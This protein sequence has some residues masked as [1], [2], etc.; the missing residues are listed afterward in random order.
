VRIIVPF[1]AGSGSDVFARTLGPKFTEAWGQQIVVENREGAGGMIGAEAVA[2]ATPDG[3]TL[4]L[5]A[6]PWAVS[7][8]L[9]A[10]PPYD[11]LRDF[12]PVGRI[13]FVPSVLVVHPSMP[14]NDITHLIKLARAKPGQLDYSSSG[15]GAPSHLFVEY[16]KAMAKVDIVVPCY[17]YGRFLETCVGSVLDQSIRD[18]RV[19]I[20]DDASTDDSLSVAKRLAETDPRISIIAHAQNKGHISTYNEGIA[21]A[22]ADYLLLL[23]AD[24]LLVAG[25]LDRAIAV[26][27]ANPDIVLTHG[28]CTVWLDGR[29]LPKLAPQQGYT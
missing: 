15:K 14:V 23:S 6:T 27:D 5:A 25:A 17:N 11:P 22:S 4:L 7:P 9:Y 1:S 20:I 18:L 16:M 8:S 21:W 12:A 19:L 24:D 13:G 26:M 10:K 28:D 3:Y 29:P 2:K